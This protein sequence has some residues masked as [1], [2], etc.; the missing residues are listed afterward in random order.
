MKKKSLIGEIFIILFILL[1]VLL[2]LVGY[3]INKRAESVILGEVISL[4]NS[5]LKQL[6]VGIRAE[7]KDVENL[8]SRIAYDSE[9]IQ[10]LRVQEDKES[11]SRKDRVHIEGLMVD[12]IWSYPSTAM[13][14]DVQLI[15]QQENIYA[16]SYAMS[17]GSKDDFT[18]QAY[19]GP[20]NEPGYQ[21]LPDF[22]LSEDGNHYYYRIPRYVTDQVEGLSQGRLILKVSEKILWNHYLRLINDDKN[23]FV[24]DREGIIISAHDKGRLNQPLEEVSAFKEKE[25][26]GPYFVGQDHVWLY[27]PIN[28]YGWAVV[29]SV[30]LDSALAPLRA[31]QTFLFL[32]GGLLV[33]GLALVL[34]ALAR[35]MAHPLGLLNDKMEAFSQ[36]DLTVEIPDSPYVEF[37]KISV[38]FNELIDQVHQ[39]LEEN[40]LKE[41]QKRLLELNFLEAQINPHF[42][43]NTLSSIRFYVEMGKTDEA[44]DMLFHFSK[45]LRRVLARTEDFVS[46]ADEISL[47]K[48]YVALQKRRY[49]NRLILDCQ[50]GQADGDRLIPSFILQPI[51]ENAIFYGIDRDQP[52]RI[53]ISSRQAGNDF[54]LIVSDNG[55]GM[56]ADQVAAI[57]S[58]ARTEEGVG[59]LNVHERI[60]LLYGPDYG[61]TIEDNKPQGTRVIMKL[62]AYL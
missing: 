15:D 56:A 3:T 25:G 49:K 4:N 58:Q 28:S 19:F 54:C 47:I 18:G 33:L 24:V 38:S 50:L 14:I 16:S 45:I 60:Q 29:E 39:L 17:L 44:E 9:L 42:I 8:A 53:V 32:L 30:T 52:V 6:A 46:L 5:A 2:A 43:Y 51:V 13:L 22:S 23:F 35:K 48:D 1:L 40:T 59:I 20:S 36:G 61:L 26:Q 27:Q 34:G 7:L 55:P 10:A 62:S 57:F 21:H 31:I 41:R 12:H 11:L 37:S